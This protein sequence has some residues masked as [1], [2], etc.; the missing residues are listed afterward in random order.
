MRRQQDRLLENK[1]AAVLRA[2]TPHWEAEAAP[3]I[4]VRAAHRYLEQRRALLDYAGARAQGWSIGSGEI[5]SSHRH[6]I[7]QRLKLAGSW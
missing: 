1:L 7:Q 3:V 5:E 6:L 4:P 2:L